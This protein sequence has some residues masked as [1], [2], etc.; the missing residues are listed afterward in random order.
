MI[1]LRR[2]VGLVLVLC[3]VLVC[4]GTAWGALVERPGWEL[5]ATSDPTNF[6][7]GGVDA[8][9]EVVAEPAAG[10]FKLSF[11]E[12]ETAA[13]P[14]GAASSVV[15]AALEALPGIGA[16]NVAVTEGPGHPG[17][18]VVTFVGA[19]GN[20]KIAELGASGASVSEKTEGESSGTLA[21]D[22]FNIGAGSS[23]GT[24][25]VTDTLPPGIHAKEAG[26]LLRTSDSGGPEHY[27]VDPM[28][29]RGVW[30]CSG[31]G[32]GPAPGVAGASVVTCTNDPV[33]LNVFAGGGG[34]P[35][36]QRNALLANPQPMVGISVEASGEASGLT[37]HVS[38]S[39]GGALTP[40][41]TSDPVTVSSAPAHGGLVS[42]DAWF[43]NSDGTIDTQAG[44]H[45]YT[46]T[47][48]YSPA[49]AL[50][51]NKEGYWAGGEVR[52]LE[53]RVPPGLIGDLRNMPQCSQSELITE[54]CP[55]SSLV[56]EVA[57][58][59]F[60]LPLE[61]RVFNVAP[62]PGEPAE[63]GLSI[64]DVVVPIRFSV[65]SGGDYAVIAH[66]DDIPQRETL[67]TVLTLW[68]VPQE[69]SHNRWRGEQGGCTQEEIEKPVFGN[70]IDYC[71][72]PQRPVV[73]P[74]LTLPTS[75]EPP[76]LERQ[77]FAFR[78][79]SGWQ[80]PNAT[81]ESSFVSHD[82]QGAPAGFTGCEELAFEPSISTSVDTSRADSPA[83]L[84]AEVKPSLGGLEE[85]Q[86]LASADIQNTTVTL[87]EGLAINPGQAAGLTACG[88]GEDALTT[89]VEKERGEENDGAPS[90][91][92]SSRV[93]SVVVK[94]PLI[95]GAVEKQ[96][97]GSVYVL[98][99]NP[100]EVRLL[101]AASADGVNVKLVGTVHLN[102]Q[103]GRLETR[104]EGTPQLP[105][106]DFRLTFDGGARA[107]LVTP[108]Q[109]GVYATDAVFTPWS[110]PFA[111]DFPTSASFALVEGAGGAPCPSGALPFA[112]VLTAGSVSAQAG[113]YTPLTVLLARG[114]GQQRIESMQ[115]KAPAGLLGMLSHVALCPEPQA[116]QGACPASS[117]IG[118]AVVT[119]GPG[120]NPL[121]LPQPGG[122][123]IPIYLTGPYAGAPFGLS[124]VTPAVAGPFNLGTIVTRARIQVDPV[125]S[126]V[127][128]TTDPLPQ[129]VKGVPTDLR[130]IYAV[131]D[132]PGFIFNPTGCEPTGFTG[133]AT[134][135]GGAATA[136]LASRFQVGGCRGLDFAPSF[137]VATQ[138]KTSKR[139]G[140]GLQVSVAYPPAPQSASQAEGQANIH[141]V[142]VTL[143]KQLPSRLTTIQQ[144]CPEAVFAANPASCPAG[145]NIGTATARTPVLANPVSGPAY[146]V[147]H[148]GA[149]FPDLVII[150][151]GEGVTVRLTGSVD[152]KHGV[153]NSTF[154]NV[155][156]VPISSFV[157]SLPEGP[158]SALAAVLPAKAKGSTCGQTLTMPTTITGQNGTQLEQT[159]KITPTGCARAKPRKKHRS[160]HAKAG[161]RHR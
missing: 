159:T 67:Q 89:S 38:I 151:Q 133:T 82:S 113:G 20:M 11:E 85:P 35:T 86:G 127:T 83:G 95:E 119:A 63:L 90:C 47:F 87:P 96:L 99:S 19:L 109:C 71:A 81:S 91:P 98:Q 57:L 5:W 75:C 1:W 160:K 33:G 48:V 103:T 153:T 61:H 94:S 56:G 112:P 131:V 24:I 144:A 118:H 105:F 154:A 137:K 107:A 145:S 74:F 123:E 15:Q 108:A 34:M 73:Q 122:P 44:S 132:R 77:G 68:G 36:M 158:H 37:N 121:T 45:P 30:D 51:A 25:T 92:A 115:V 14:F 152:I 155:P 49:T 8:V 120:S 13:I 41:A 22:V 102:E 46:A 156:D 135:A 129:I 142:A 130:S 23:N 9:Q 149:A 117:Q 148:G 80:E 114:D 32:P 72:R 26:D 134:A 28:I 60:E 42:G 27:G 62:A 55:P 111:P 150:L 16:G 12:H 10:S 29:L 40:A 65:R 70:S 52:S 4:S 140:A 39:G 106:S 69:A 58:S 147:S 84:T 146:L 125:T 66:I 78:E 104:F 54:E 53:T 79:L 88:L 157:L 126:Q 97:E 59:T 21:I 64:A 141:S 2:S 31:N 7:P 6:L 139:D 161:S 128:I 17:V 124:I 138:A 116:A 136:T 101:L 43:S 93:G 110:A 143:P 100:P 76:S 18:Y 3:A 50:N